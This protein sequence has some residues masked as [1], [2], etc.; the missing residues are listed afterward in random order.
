MTMKTAKEIA[1]KYGLCNCD[2]AYTS[3]GLTA[4]DCPLHGFAV[5]EAMEEY[6]QSVAEDLRERIAGGFHD[7]EEI[8]YIKNTEIILP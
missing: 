3:R 1:I 4:P 7:T 5:E 8:N 6:A 2:E